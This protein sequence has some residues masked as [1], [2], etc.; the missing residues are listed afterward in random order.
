MERIKIGLCLLISL[1]FLVSCAPKT[2]LLKVPSPFDPDLVEEI[3]IPESQVSEIKKVGQPQ[4]ILLDKDFK[5]TNDPI[6]ARYVAYEPKEYAKVVAHFKREKA[7]EKI[8][9]KLE[10]LSIEHIVIINGQSKILAMERTMRQLG[11]EMTNIQIQKANA[12]QSELAWLKAEN[13]F[14]KVIIVAGAAIAV[15]LAF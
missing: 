8:A 12:L 9:E 11:T 3:P 15:V 4:K 6:K 14:L 2:D 1:I 5:K 13:I 10:D 7:L